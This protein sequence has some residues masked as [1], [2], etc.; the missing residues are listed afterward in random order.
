MGGAQPDETAASACGLLA[1]T[2][3]ATPQAATIAS[4]IHRHPHELLSA[5]AG[6]LSRPAKRAAARSL[7]YSGRMGAN[8]SGVLAWMIMPS[9]PALN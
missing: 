7:A 1:V 8:W 5:Y 9:A 3:E 2:R 6:L 4:A